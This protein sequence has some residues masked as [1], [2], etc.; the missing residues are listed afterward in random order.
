MACFEYRVTEVAVAQDGF[1][2]SAPDVPY[3]NDDPD[4]RAA[5][6]QCYDEVVD[7]FAQ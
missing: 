3:M 7:R 2:Y 4:F 5:A 1:H 6:T